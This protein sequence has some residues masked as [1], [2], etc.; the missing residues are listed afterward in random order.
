MPYDPGKFEGEPASSYL[1]YLALMDG[2]DEDAGSHA[3]LRGVLVPGN[4]LI[5]AAKAVGYTP[6]EIKESLV[7]LFDMAGA[8]MHES[9]Q[10]FVYVTIYDNPSQ[11]E[12]MWKEIVESYNGS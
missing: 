9:D 1:V 3:L 8:I 11:L 5:L 6:E 7:N 12:Q 10:G 2:A 4:D